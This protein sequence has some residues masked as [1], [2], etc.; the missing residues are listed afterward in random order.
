VRRAGSAFISH[1]W[2]PAFY[3]PNFNSPVTTYCVPAY[4]WEL[5]YL[6]CGSDWGSVYKHSVK[7]ACVSSIFNLGPCLFSRRGVF[8]TDSS[9]IGKEVWLDKEGSAPQ[10]AS[11]NTTFF[12]F[13]LWRSC[14]PPPCFGAAGVEM[15]VMWPGL[16]FAHSLLSEK[17]LGGTC[18]NM[19]QGTTS[20]VWK[21][22][23]LA[24]WP[25]T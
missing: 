10:W 21:L 14:L 3:P 20:E 4:W 5:V 13:G 2:F 8:W 6:S 19:V 17:C 22:P 15:H 25:V 1:I 9:N 24:Q 12:F 23:C 7:C 16:T 18:P 11:L